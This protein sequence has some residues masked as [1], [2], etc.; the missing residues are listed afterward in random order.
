MQFNENIKIRSR[1]RRRVRWSKIFMLIIAFLL[2]IALLLVGYAYWAM[3]PMSSAESRV[4]HLVRSKAG[5]VDLDQL[6]VNYRQGTTYGVV[7]TNAKGQKRVAIVQGDS[8]KVKTF[9]R[10]AGMSNAALKQ[11]I[12]TKY[13]PKK[14]YEANISMYKGVLVWEIAYENQKG[15]LNYLTLDFKTGKPYRVINGL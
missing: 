9:P 15:Q 7:G 11:L 5:F 6:T 12:T 4:E 2:V 3:T 14:L 13:H 10:S 8:N 1:R